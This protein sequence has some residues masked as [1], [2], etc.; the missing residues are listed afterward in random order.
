MPTLRIQ[1]TD[2]EYD[3]S[4]VIHFNEGLIG[5]PHLRRMALVAQTEIAP[6]LWLASLDDERLAFLVIDP[7]AVF[8]DYQIALPDEVGARI[9]VEADERPLVLSI[10]VIAA[11]WRNSTVNLRA[12]LVV[13]PSKMRGMQIILS[14]AP[15][16]VAEPLPLAQAA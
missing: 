5:L 10:A 3:Q 4:S 2:I 9:G 8:R 14:D 11:E 16:R 12:P 1:G 6:F 15:Y 13:A 7:R